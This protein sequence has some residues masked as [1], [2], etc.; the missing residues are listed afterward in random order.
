VS[1]R[2]FRFKFATKVTFNGYLPDRSE[3]QTLRH[4]RRRGQGEGVEEG[5]G[6]VR[7]GSARAVC[8]A[9]EE[10]GILAG[11]DLGTVAPAYADRLLVAVTEQ[12]T[13]AELDRLVSALDAV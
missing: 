8:T 13:R 1:D 7:G 2:R 6:R 3:D 12:R 4:H 11:I 5:R 10:Q 9:L